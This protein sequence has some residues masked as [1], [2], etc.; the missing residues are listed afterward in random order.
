[1]KKYLL[2]LFVAILPAI[3]FTSCSDDD[4]NLPLTEA[5]LVGSWKSVRIVGWEKED[6]KIVDRWDEAFTDE[7]YTFNADGTGV[8]NDSGYTS[9]FHWC[10]DGNTLYID[11][12]S[13]DYTI[14]QLTSNTLV[15]GEYYNDG[16]GS[17]Q[18]DEYT[19]TR[20]VTE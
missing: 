17:E 2:M 12:W 5:N 16:D 8:Y 10:I 7:V 1:M 14:K 11:A 18:Y 19:Y 3:A 15:L 4:D 20:V 13:E 6:G 9:S